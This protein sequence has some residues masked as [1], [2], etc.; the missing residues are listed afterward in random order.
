MYDFEL[1]TKVNIIELDRVGVIIGIS[2]NTFGVRYEV[3]YFDNGQSYSTIF[4]PFEL[5]VAK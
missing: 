3:R 5:E 4:F 2:I 1:A